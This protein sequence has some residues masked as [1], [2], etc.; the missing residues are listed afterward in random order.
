VAG[1]TGLAGGVVG[2]VAGVAG[3]AG[4]VVGPVAGVVGPVAGVPGLANGL[5]GFAG[6]RCCCV[7]VLSSFLNN[8]TDGVFHITTL[9]VR[10]RSPPFTRGFF[11][12][13]GTPSLSLDGGGRPPR[14]RRV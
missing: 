11:R 14:P 2:P 8:G 7:I 10:S 4:G 6:G 9:N 5:H 13:T 3:L 12:L 1:V